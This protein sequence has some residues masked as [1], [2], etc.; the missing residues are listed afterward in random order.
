MATDISSTNSGML[1]LSDTVVDNGKSIKKGVQT[2][3]REDAEKL[4]KNIHEQLEHTCLRDITVVIHIIAATKSMG[5]KEL[6]IEMVRVDD[7]V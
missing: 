5:A 4:T 7:A 1:L 3:M 6:L 2:E